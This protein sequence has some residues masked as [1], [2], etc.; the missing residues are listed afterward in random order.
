MV[1][2]INFLILFIVLCGRFVN[3]IVAEGRRGVSVEYLR[4][5]SDALAHTLVLQHL[6]VVILMYRPQAEYHEYLVYQDTG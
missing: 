5:I 1:M 4:V 2:V 3:D 6:I